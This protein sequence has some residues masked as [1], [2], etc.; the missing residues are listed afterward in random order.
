M[1]QSVRKVRNPKEILERARAIIQNKA[2]LFAKIRARKA[3]VTE[4]FRT[5]LGRLMK[6]ARLF[7]DGR[8]SVSWDVTAALAGAG[9]YLP[10]VGS[11][12]SFRY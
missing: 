12:G 3:K 7:R 10:E 5:A 1:L 6:S 8:L 11:G 4:E 9:N 2:E